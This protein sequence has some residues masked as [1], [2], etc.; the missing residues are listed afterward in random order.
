MV[1][2]PSQ[3]TALCLDEVDVFVLAGGLG[4]R[5]RPVLG[6][7]PKL[8]APLMRRTYLDHL[9]DWLQGFGA[10]RAVLGLGH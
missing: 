6:D 1:P 4:T 5:V 8:L 10:Q 3:F 9:L 2:T 7:T